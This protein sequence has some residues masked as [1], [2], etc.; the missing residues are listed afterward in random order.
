M[1]D[2]WEGFYEGQQDGREEVNDQIWRALDNI[3]IEGELEASLDMIE[4]IIGYKPA[5]KKKKKN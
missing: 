5:A 1:D 2:Y 4:K 3:Y